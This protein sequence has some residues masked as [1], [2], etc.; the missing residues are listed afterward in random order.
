MEG[1]LL[2][3]VVCRFVLVCFIDVIFAKSLFVFAVSLLF[4]SVFSWWFPYYLDS[5]IS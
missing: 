3:V 5:A 4:L 1:D 2:F